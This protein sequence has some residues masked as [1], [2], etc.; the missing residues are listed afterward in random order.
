MIGMSKLDF[1]DVFLPWRNSRGGIAAQR[2]FHCFT[3]TE[4]ENLTK[5]AGFKIKK[6]WREGKDPRTNIYIIAEKQKIPDN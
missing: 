3:K 2:Y 4:L 1:R 5:E 6:I